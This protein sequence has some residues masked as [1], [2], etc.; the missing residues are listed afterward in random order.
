MN[1]ELTLFPELNVQ[2]EGD[3]HNLPC[4]QGLSEESINLLESHVNNIH[5]ISNKA[6][7]DIAIEL[8]EARDE[9]K[10]NKHGGFEGWVD[11]RLK[12][13]RTTAYKIIWRYEQFGTV[14]NYEQLD[15]VLSAQYQLSAPTAPKE[16]RQEAI[17]RAESGEKITVAKSNELIK[18]WQRIAE[19][20]DKEAKDAQ[21]KLGIF[22]AHSQLAQ[23]K[24]DEL[25]QQITALEEKL[26]TA[27]TPEKVEVIP[28]STLDKIA[29]LEALVKKLKEHS[30]NLSNENDRLVDDL[31]KQ[32]EANE[33]RRRQE[34]YEAEVKSNWKKATDSLH[35]ALH[36]FIG[37]IPS[38]IAMQIFE[39]D[40]WARC[41]GV[42][43]G[44]KHILHIMGKMQ[45]ARYSNHQFVESV[46]ASV[47]AVVE[48]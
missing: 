39:G 28:Q 48:G 31:R 14:H 1:N 16:A 7:F 36:Q 4:Y 40:D 19:E 5:K 17:E 9:Y 41:D 15:I 44:M 43:E 27:Q 46:V 3:I 11:E 6:S 42:E 13:G 8:C 21:S 32:R 25:S 38:P 37:S 33:A 35:K 12:I 10:H 29:N 2:E 47:P 20:K 26:R 22:Q 34:Q 24:V 18:K 45:D 23:A 30:Q